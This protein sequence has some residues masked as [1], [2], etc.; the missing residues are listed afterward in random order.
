MMIIAGYKYW[1]TYS[2]HLLEK[3][4]KYYFMWIYIRRHI[5]RA[6]NHSDVSQDIYSLNLITYFNA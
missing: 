4:T 2:L 3:S 1:D 6:W 5:W